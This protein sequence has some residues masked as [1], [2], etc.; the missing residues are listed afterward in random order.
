MTTQ[1]SPATGPERLD[2]RLYR[3]TRV[4]LPGAETSPG[5]LDAVG[6]D[7][8]KGSSAAVVVLESAD[9]ALLAMLAEGLSPACVGRRIGVNER[10]VR[11]RLHRLCERLRVTTPMQAVVLAVR[12][13][14]I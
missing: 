10:T 4:T 2:F 14:I 9:V 13:S 6:A 5:R 11:R 3:R 1:A 12:H 7:L 8:H